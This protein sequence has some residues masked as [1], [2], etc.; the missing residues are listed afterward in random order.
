MNPNDAKLQEFETLLA[1]IEKRARFQRGMNFALWGVVVGMFAF[2]SFYL[3][4]IAK[5]VLSNESGPRVL[6]QVARSVAP[7][8]QKVVAK[9]QESIPALVQ[10][11]LDAAES[12]LP[13]LEADVLAKFDQN[14]DRLFQQ[15]GETVRPMVRKAIEQDLSKIRALLEKATKDETH[16]ALTKF[17]C[18]RFA[19]HLAQTVQRFES[20]LDGVHQQIARYEADDKTL[21]KKEL[22]E[23]QLL[24]SL[25]RLGQEPA[26]RESL[27]SLREAR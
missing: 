15:L 2:Y 9:I 24:A 26:V 22:A 5:E 27:Q 6:T 12:Y 20:T 18:D 11:S 3:P 1:N 7:S 13:D 4:G 10:R 19:E 14:T 17:I 25:V 16:E 23:K 8:P 21:S